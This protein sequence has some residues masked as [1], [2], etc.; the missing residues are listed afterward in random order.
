MRRIRKLMDYAKDM[1]RAAL[2]VLILPLFISIM[3]WGA[4]GDNG[5]SK[6]AESRNT[7]KAIAERDVLYQTSTIGALMFG[8]YDG[9]VSFAELKQ[10]GGFGLGTV[11]Q[12]DGE[13][14]AL[15][16]E[17]YHIKTDGIAYKLTDT[18]LTPFANVTFFD[19]DLS[20]Q[21][22]AGMTYDQLEKAIDDMLPTKNTFYAIKIEGVFNYVKTRSVPIQ[23]KPYIP[24]LDVIKN[25]VFFEFENI[26]GTLVGFRCPAYISGVNVPGYHFHFITD[27]KTRGGHVIALETGDVQ[28]S[29]DQT[30]G[31]YM[32]LPDSNAFD[33]ADLS[34]EGLDDVEK[35]KSSL[36]FYGD[37]K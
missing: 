10:H 37:Y 7:I 30:R 31:F 20:L 16:G 11:D 1:K 3:A 15:D 14:I 26:K 29:I 33:G 9:D 25:Q 4:P 23:Q 6:V 28:L 12:L 34:V 35:P 2:G 22:E 24:L 36:R 21:L 27:D 32:A 8:V 19:A 18:Q 17:F 13:M 5:E